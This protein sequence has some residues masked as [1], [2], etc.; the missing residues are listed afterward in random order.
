[1][2]IVAE[3]SLENLDAEKLQQGLI[4]PERAQFFIINENFFNSFD[5]AI[6]TAHNQV[7]EETD[8]H[9]ERIKENSRIL[10]L[11][12]LTLLILHMLLVIWQSARMHSIIENDQTILLT[13][14]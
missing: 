8:I 14:G 10:Q 9:T 4:T 2:A 13:I 6:D 1:M 5:E 3:A 7:E 11:I 12:L